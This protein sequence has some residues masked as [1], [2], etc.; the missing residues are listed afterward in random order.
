MGISKRGILYYADLLWTVLRHTV[1]MV[2]RL[3]NLTMK[4]QLFAT[5]FITLARYKHFSSYTVAIISV[6][7][8]DKAKIYTDKNWREPES[9]VDISVQKCSSLYLLLFVKLC[10]CVTFAFIQ[11]KGTY[12]LH[13][14]KRETRYM[15]TSTCIQ[16][17]FSWLRIPLHVTVLSGQCVHCDPDTNIIPC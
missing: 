11:I 2:L 5:E 7:Y 1:A 6:I 14:C 15:Y 9:K 12:N 16:R 8:Y 17:C 3:Q 4:W 10:N 13:N